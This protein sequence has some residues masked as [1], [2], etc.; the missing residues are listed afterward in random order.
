MAYRTHKVVPRESKNSTLGKIAQS[1]SPVLPR[2]SFIEGSL[3][4]KILSYAIVLNKAFTPKELQN[5][6]GVQQKPSDL[7]RS[8]LVLEKNGSVAKLNEEY[9]AVTRKGIQQFYDFRAR[10]TS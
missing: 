10:K 9:W 7:K 5:L 2:P 8:L 1:D 4:H 3:A 6:M